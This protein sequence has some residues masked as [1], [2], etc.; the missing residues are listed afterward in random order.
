[1]AT[2]QELI[3]IFQKEPGFNRMF[4]LFREKYRSYENIGQSVKISLPFP[5][6]YERK[7]LEGFF[8][9]SFKG[10][11]TIIISSAKFQKAIQKTK[12][13]ETFEGYD[14]NDLIQ[15]YYGNELTSKKHDRKR[16]EQKK[17]MFFQSLLS[18]CDSGSAFYR[19]LIFIKEQKSAPRIHTMYKS[20]PYLLNHLLDLIANLFTLLPLNE[21]VYL[22]VLSRDLTGDPHA[23][24]PQKVSGKMILYALQIIDYVDHGVEILRKPTAEQMT[25]IL[26]RHRILRDDLLNFSTVYNGIAINKNGIDNALFAGARIERAFFHLP[27]REIQKIGSFRTTN[28]GDLFMIENSAVSSF[29]ANQLSPDETGP[30]IVLGCG[31]LKTATLKLL[32]LYVESSSGYI[33]YSGDFDPEGLIIAQKLISRYGSRLKLWHYTKADYL[34]TTQ[35]HKA[36]AL[37]K[38]RLKKLNCVTAKELIS[39][40]EAMLKLGRAGYQEAILQD[41]VED[42]EHPH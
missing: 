14:I 35:S 16:F 3:Q 25:D 7:V 40:K 28:A 9:E 18:K 33:H 31:Q 23:L 37:P 39:V 19:F 17:D 12:Y 38:S 8:G 32:D 6:V 15:M 5:T 1:M 24:D 30:T 4:S 20:D 22:P 13:K 36:V 2:M 27:L 26:F 29:L 42:L 10:V 21:D 34:L 11:K 41:L